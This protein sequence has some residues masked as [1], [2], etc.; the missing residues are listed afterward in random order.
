MPENSLEE[1]DEESLDYYKTYHN[2]KTRCHRKV[3]VVRL[4]IKNLKKVGVANTSH[5]PY[6]RN[7]E[8]KLGGGGWNSR[9][10]KILL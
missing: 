9:F 10:W 3:G 1:G 7:L 8:P 2:R 5:E 6:F 4:I